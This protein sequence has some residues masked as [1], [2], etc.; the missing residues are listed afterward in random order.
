MT[1]PLIRRFVAGIWKE[2]S[3]VFFSGLGALLLWFLLGQKVA[4]HDT[5][6]VGVR[7]ISAEE[8]YPPGSGLFIRIPKGI[9]VSDV[10]PRTL[11]LRVTGTREDLVRLDRSL[12]GTFE[13][14]AGFLRGSEQVTREL[15]VRERFHFGRFLSLPSLSLDSEAKIQ[16]SLARRH[17]IN[18]ALSEENLVFTEPGLGQGVEIEFEPTMIQVSGPG[19]QA[20]LV[21]ENPGLFKLASINRVA[22]DSATRGKLQVRASRGLFRGAEGELERLAAEDQLIRITITV[23]ESFRTVTFQDLEVI[24]LVP[25]SAWPAGVNRERPLSLNPDAVKVIIDVPEQYFAGGVG[26]E[27][28]LKHLNLFVDLG[29][30][31]F[32]TAAEN[33]PVHVEGL[34]LGAK[35]RVEPPKVDV[36]WN[37]P[38]PIPGPE[39][40]K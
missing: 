23:T 40:G 36:I 22:F 25:A 20:R 16:L 7:C 11:D 30:M 9:A 37:I 17:N 32:D 29:E 5:I 18:V 27:D 35:A 12:K 21:A 24:S 15:S 3:R 2:R 38:D 1:E 31:P 10:E 4:D 6:A 19:E 28:L 14:P 34:P 33:L 8:D 13:V 26:E 39:D